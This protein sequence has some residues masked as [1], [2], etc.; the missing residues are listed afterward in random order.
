MSEDLVTAK[1]RVREQV[2]A[3]RAAWAT[4]LTP[5][6]REAA[7]A[8]LAANLAALVRQR[9]ARTVSCYSPIGDEPDTRPFLQWAR[10]AGIEV[11]LPTARLDGRLEW[12]HDTGD[13]QV[14][15]PFGIA[16]PAGEARG[17]EA[18]LTV[19]LMLIPACAVGHDGMRLG[20]GRGYFD[21]ALEALDHFEQD[22]RP[23]VFAVTHDADYLDT[24]PA[25]PHD[26]PVAGLV[27]QERTLVF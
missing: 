14:V 25:E 10:D 11:L 26:R 2:R 13:A 8:D 3:R 23:A 6:Q 17:P 5:E 7:A 16:E 9:S 21:R 19:D 18:L 22:H 20:W 1:R 27:T 24:V 15:G 12:L 4:S